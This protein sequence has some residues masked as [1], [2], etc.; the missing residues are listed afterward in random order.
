MFRT[1]IGMGALGALVALGCAGVI[2]LLAP[3]GV[4]SAH[5]VGHM[6][7]FTAG[8]ALI[9]AVLARLV[10]RRLGAPSWQGARAAALVTAVVAVGVTAKAV[11][12]LGTGHQLSADLVEPA[13]M[14]G[15]G[16]AV[17]RANLVQAKVVAPDRPHHPDEVTAPDRWERMTRRRT[18][19]VSTNAAGL[20]GPPIADP[21]QGLR[22]VCIGDSVTMGWGVADTETYPAQLAQLSGAEVINAGMPAMK[23]TTIAGWLRAHGSELEMD[24]L[25]LAVRPNHMLADPWQDYAHMLQEA[26][27][28]VAPAK[29]LVVL[30]PISTFDPLGSRMK[31]EEFERISAMAGTVPVLDLATALHRSNNT[32]MMTIE[33]S[34]QTMLTQPHNIV[35]AEGEA[36]GDGI[37]PEIIAAFEANPGIQETHFFDGGHPDAA[38]Y[39]RFAQRVFVQLRDL[40][41]VQARGH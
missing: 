10:F 37:A 36:E 5:A 20:R 11:H 15:P 23:P 14:L 35:W 38:G 34:H 16:A 18:F 28:V 27:R 17:L 24:V 32:I 39:K 7:G 13:P 25:V 19:Y 40:G 30:T 22:I 41:W 31:Q 12:D 9:S 26:I 1:S 4:N 21:K 6:L 3:E 33:G 2:A 8:T 29:V